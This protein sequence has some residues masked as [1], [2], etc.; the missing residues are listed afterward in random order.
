MMRSPSRAFAVVALLLLLTGCMSSNDDLQSWIAEVKAKP[1]AP[2]DALPPLRTYPPIEYSAQG[3]RDPFSAPVANSR[4]ASGPRPDPNRRKE[5]LEAFPLDALRMV[6]T[7]GVD[8]GAVALVLAP[9][10][11]T[12]RVKLGDY[13]GQ[14]DGKVVQVGAERI[15]L[16]ELV[17]DGAG[18]WLER[19]ASLALEDK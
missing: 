14:N 18:G 11:V 4:E 6:G 13:V 10:N 7:I 5:A 1:A 3:L 8:Q 16:L 2:L 15:G 17:S 9:D 19:Q 12:Y